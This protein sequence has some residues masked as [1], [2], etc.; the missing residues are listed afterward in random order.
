MFSQNIFFIMFAKC[1]FII[2]WCLADKILPQNAQIGT[3]R[4]DLVLGYKSN[5]KRIILV[6]NTPPIVKDL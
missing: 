2:E 3:E 4:K 6:Q 1:Y 5:Y